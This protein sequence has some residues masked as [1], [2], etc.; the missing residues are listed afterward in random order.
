VTAGPAPLVSVIVPAR[1]EEGDIEACLRAVAASDWPAADLEVIVVDGGSRDETRSVAEAELGR[2]LFRRAEVVSNPA[3]TTPSNLNAGLAAAT[4]EILV[5]V[6]ARSLVPPVYVRRCVED[7]AAD[8]GV[9]VVGGRQWAVARDPSVL[10]AGI[11]RALN[12]RWGMGL[13]RY[14]R[15]AASGPADTVYLGAFRTAELR[16]A[17]GW[18]ERFGTNQDFELN[19]RMGRDGTVWFDHRLVVGY[20]PR[21]SLGALLRQ[22]HRFGR[23][24]VRYWRMTGDRPQP[25]QVV[26]IAGPLALAALVTV[27]VA[28][29]P[30][31]L[32]ALVVLKVL[33]VLGAIA[34]EVAGSRESSPGGPAEHAVAM[35]AL[36]ASSGGWLSGVVR[37]LATS[38]RRAEGLHPAPGDQH[39]PPGEHGVDG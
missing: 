25:R 16:A 14:R 11:A 4:G 27:V 13:S 8:P 21:A 3:G 24:K 9:R 31:R 17:G 1:N 15:G 29:S 2:H 38:P 19:R 6:D 5:R 7:L 36:A 18:N 35:A 30:R 28:V 22:Y 33:A 32:R 39:A 23:W 26:L 34:V 10:A 20:L 37:E 12:N